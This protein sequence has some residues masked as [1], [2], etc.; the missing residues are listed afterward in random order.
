MDSES[1]GSEGKEGQKHGQQDGGH[2]EGEFCCTHPY[3]QQR[4][5][6]TCVAT[7]AASRQGLSCE[8]LPQL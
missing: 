7:K 4:G 8:T 2:M 5:W 1:R 3:E 6:S